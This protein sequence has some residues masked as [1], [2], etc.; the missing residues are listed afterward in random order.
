MN[1]PVHD[2][3]VHDGERFPSLSTTRINLLLWLL[4]VITNVTDVLAS[5]HALAHGAIELNPIVALLLESHGM[6]GLV[7]VKGFWMV[8]LL[9][10]LPY[11]RGWVQWLYA[12]VVFAYLLLSV[13]HLYHI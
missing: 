8:L 12:L 5:K 9:L 6:T 3:P 13:Y 11:V 2:S 1:S 7:V 4:L 10:L